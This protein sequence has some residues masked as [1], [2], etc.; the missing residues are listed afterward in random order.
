M[1]VVADQLSICSETYDVTSLL[2]KG[3]D[4]RFL[5]RE[6]DD[7]TYPEKFTPT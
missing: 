1:N 4:Q 7:V 2:A 6:D 5:A 3:F